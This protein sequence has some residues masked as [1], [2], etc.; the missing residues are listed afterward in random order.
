M[1]STC[2]V[3]TKKIVVVIII[4]IIIICKTLFLY[5]EPFCQPPDRILIK[6]GSNSCVTYAIFFFFGRKGWLG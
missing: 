3:V 6:K 4:I 1:A 2:E 5:R